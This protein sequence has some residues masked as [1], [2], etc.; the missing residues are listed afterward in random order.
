MADEFRLI[1]NYPNYSVSNLGN[2]R[3][4]STGRI[5][6]PITNQQNGY[7]TVRLYN[8]EGNG[9]K[10]NHRLVA[11]AFLENPDNFVDIDHIDR[12]RINNNIEN[13]RF[14]SRSVNCKN[15]TSYKNITYEYIDELP[16]DAIVV[17]NYGNHEFTDLY[18]SHSTRRFIFNNGVHFRLLHNNLSNNSYFVV[19]YDTTNNKTQIRLNKFQRIHDLI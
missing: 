11:E 14:V 13:L 18:Y 1:N 5:L 17:E 3:N 12:N 4:N 10:Y 8:E 15:K 6:A 16:E 9:A 7:L 19:V 2:V